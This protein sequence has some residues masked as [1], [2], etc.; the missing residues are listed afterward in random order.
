[1]SLEDFIFS[2][3]AQIALLGIQFQW[4]ADTQA[5]L[6]GAKTDK[7]IMIKNMKKTEALLRCAVCALLWG[8]W[9]SRL[10]PFAPALSPAPPKQLFPSQKATA[11]SQTPIPQTPTP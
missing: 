5:A 2:H 4:T 9:R 10:L 8:R 6:A 11:P 7:S 3:P 1:M